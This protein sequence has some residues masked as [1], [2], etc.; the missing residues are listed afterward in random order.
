LLKFDPLFRNPHLATIAGNF[1]SRPDGETR[2]PIRAVHYETEP[3]VKIL[4]HEQCPEKEPRGELVLIHGL[5][6]SGEA[7]YVRSLAFAALERGYAVQRFHMRGCGGTDDL[8]PT[9]YHAGQTCDLLAF[10][11]A[12]K[13][14]HAGPIF[15][16]GFS[17]GGNVA[18][19]LAGESAERASNLLAGVCSVST[20]IDLASC[21]E[22]LGRR[23]NFIYQQ[24]FL[25][26]LKDRIRRRHVL[27]PDT[28]TLEHLPK[29][30][31]IV[32]FDNYY[33]ARLFGFGTAANYFRTQ[34]SNQFLGQ[35]RIPGL[36]ITAQD[37]PLVPFEVYGHPAIRANPNLSLLAPEH[38]GH[39]GFLSRRK[40]RFWVDEVVMEWIAAH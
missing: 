29:I 21:A 34:S 40:P 14:A 9:A 8:A 20:P 26:R 2:W 38:G 4:V 22:A 3:G 6:G 32:D 33:T 39:L 31:T 19:K 12:R 36:L 28:Y 37:D 7:G 30:R 11:E 23:E 24:R 16:I 15:L 25:S 27:A 35:I 18:L 17:L 1:W 5:E 10:L 13:R